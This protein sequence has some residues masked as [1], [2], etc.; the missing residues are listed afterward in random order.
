MPADPTACGI[1]VGIGFAFTTR[2]GFRRT[3]SGQGKGDRAQPTLEERPVKKTLLAALLAAIVPAAGRH[4]RR[5]HPVGDRTCRF[6]GIPEKNTID[7]L[8][9]PSA[10]RR[11][12]TSSSTTPPDTTT[13]VKNAKKLIS[14]NKVDV[15][16][17]S[18]TPLNSLAMIDAAAEGETPM[19]SMAASARTSN[20]WTTRSAGSSRRR[21]TMPR[22]RRPSSST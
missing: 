2:T 10:A 7:P 9:G 11:S 13:A 14:E 6:L 21:R 4:H 12:I 15:V 3:F 5:R 17:G 16:I 20:P 19:I 1:P 8:P 22:C 18:T